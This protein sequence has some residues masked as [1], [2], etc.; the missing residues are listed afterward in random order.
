M[1]LRAFL[2]EGKAVALRTFLTG[3][4]RDRR[5]LIFLTFVNLGGFLYG[6]EWYR[7]QLAT[8]PAWAWP[9]TADCP[10]SALLFGSVTALLA[11][12]RHCEPLQGLAYVAAL[13]YGLWTVLIIAQSWLAGAPLDL[14]GFNL[15]WTH[16]GMVGESLLF[17]M[18]RPPRLRWVGL[19]AVWVAL[20]TVLDYGFGLHPTL[21]AQTPVSLALGAS[22]G[23]GVLAVGIFSALA[24]RGGARGRPA[25]QV[26]AEVQ[27]GAGEWRSGAS[28]E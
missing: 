19:G 7:G 17:G 27:G 10:V 6:M 2:A 16:A 14:D 3:I 5:W 28:W 22:V 11:L 9:V 8:L 13:K 23:L 12:D 1:A 21:P 20:N 25:T 26:A 4:P 24:F 18:V 15:M